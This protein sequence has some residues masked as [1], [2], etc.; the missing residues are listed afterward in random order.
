MAKGDLIRQY[1]SDDQLRRIDAGVG[2][3]EKN[4]S[5]EL[6]VVIREKRDWIAKL[7]RLSIRRLAVEEFHR[8]RM[9]K[10]RDR[11]GVILF[12]LLE[13]RQF[14]IYGD[15]GIHRQIGQPAWDVIAGDISR[16]A[17]EENLFAAIQHGLVRAGELLARNFPIKPDDVNELP[18]EVVIR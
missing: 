16:I 9:H 14:Y 17:I 18:N 10:T 5:G 6:R 11:T 3:Q 2:A 1:L 7:L 15:L 4:T 13:D 12:I 8:L